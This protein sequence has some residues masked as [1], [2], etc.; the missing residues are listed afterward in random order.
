[1]EKKEGEISWGQTLIK[2]ENIIRED[3]FTSS[4]LTFYMKSNITLTDKRLITHYPNII[5]KLI[6]LWFNN[7]TFNLKQ[8]SWV[9]LHTKYKVIKIAISIIVILVWLFSGELFVLLLAWFLWIILL[10]WWIETYIL[11]TTSW[12]STCCPVVFWEKWKVQ[13]LINDLNSKIAEG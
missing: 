1:M 9:Q 4:P 8:I 7:T 10:S 12:R 6:P 3:N 2:W 13:E 5:L 11:V